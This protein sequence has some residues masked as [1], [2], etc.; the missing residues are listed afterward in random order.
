MKKKLAIGE[1]GAK[2]YEKKITDINFLQGFEDIVT[3][4][5]NEATDRLTDILD[6]QQEPRLSESEAN[7]AASKINA[8]LKS[9]SSQTLIKL[10][11]LLDS[12]VK[13]MSENLMND[14]K[15]DLKELLEL[16]SKLPFN[17]LSIVAFELDTQNLV[18]SNKQTE[19]KTTTEKYKKPVTKELY[20]LRKG[21]GAGFWDYI[22]PKN[23]WRK[24]KVTTYEDAERKQTHTEH[25]I[26]W[27]NISMDVARTFRKHINSLC[28]NALAIANQNSSE[29]KDAFLVRVRQVNK[30]LGD[31]MDLLQSHIQ[32]AND[33][34]K[35]IERKKREMEQSE[36]LLSELNAI[37]SK[38]TM[39][40][41]I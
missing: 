40:A 32:D 17:P 4:T 2:K 21:A 19:T 3:D 12:N 15:N 20:V 1:S 23:W 24:E 8:A 16:D 41:D 36:K 11:G 10:E 22:N 14:F 30:K 33:K 35:D 29:I 18:G 25:Y 34:E 28:E 31:E 37:K 38:S 5:L 26:S 27:V 13:T 6:E 39:L 9:L 7:K